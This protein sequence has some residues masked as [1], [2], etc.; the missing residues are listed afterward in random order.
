MSHS[1]SFNH[2]TCITLDS[3]TAINHSK[4]LQYE[5]LHFHHDRLLNTVGSSFAGPC[6][7][8]PLSGVF[9]FHLQGVDKD[10]PNSTL[11]CLTLNHLDWSGGGFAPQPSYLNFPLTHFISFTWLTWITEPPVFATVTSAD[12][13]SNCKL[14]IHRSGHR[15]SSEHG[16]EWKDV[17]SGFSTSFL[18]L[19]GQKGKNPCKR[20]VQIGRLFARLFGLHLNHQAT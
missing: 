16:A 9:L 18:L 1:I 19:P 15:A 20:T 4:V 8:K 3:I 13:S 2:G 17:A 6:G 14:Q 5:S 12:V 10:S 7:L 11:T